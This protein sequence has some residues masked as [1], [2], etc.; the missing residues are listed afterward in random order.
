MNDDGVA[1]PIN[2]PHDMPTPE[3]V[4]EQLAGILA[5]K[6]F[7]EAPRSRQ[8]LTYVVENCLKGDTE[9]LK[10]SVIALEVFGKADFDA[11]I[12]S[13]VRGAAR[14][15]R[16]NIRRFYEEEV[17]TAPV[18]IDL[19]EGHY[20]PTFAARHVQPAI[21]KEAVAPRYWRNLPRLTA[22]AAGLLALA[23]VI[24]LASL[25]LPYSPE[26]PPQYPS[27]LLSAATSTGKKPAFC[28]TRHVIGSLLIT[29]DGKKLYAFEQKGKNVDVFD[30]ATLNI[31][32]TITLPRAVYRA[33]IT[34]AGRYIYAGSMVDGLISIDTRTD[35]VSSVIPTGGPVMHVAVTP[36]NQR[37]F[38]AMGSKGLLEADPNTGHLRVISEHVSPQFV[39]VDPD[40][41]LVYV[42]YMSGGPGGW[43]GHDAVIAYDVKTGNIVH[44]IRQ[45]PRVGG[46]ILFRASGDLAIMNGLDACWTPKY[47]QA[48]CPYVP[49]HVYE[50][51]WPKENNRVEVVALP[52][53]SDQGALTPD[54][55]R[56]VY[57]GTGISVL[58][59]ARRTTVERFNPGRDTTNIA[60]TPKMD[61]VFATVW[62]APGMFV[63]KPDLQECP[64]SKIGLVNL[65]TGD[66]TADD[67]VGT[68]TAV[69]Q[70]PP[71]FAP[72]IAGQAFRFTAKP[73]GF[74]KVAFKDACVMC[75]EEW[76]IGLYVQFA[77]LGDEATILQRTSDSRPGY[78]LSKF[79]DDRIR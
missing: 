50:F 15:L 70:S 34:R 52:Y 22:I 29:P 36:D 5:S 35:Q 37:I 45:V 26:P 73:D 28:D 55:T 11:Q 20:V 46:P 42:S 58:D 78:R 18:L 74:L 63:F 8:L 54:G 12:D 51:L 3:A 62:A 79:R 25:P 2:T 23:L 40:G 57:S 61:R 21:P 71:A 64:K 68:G 47:D 24:A 49:S 16:K 43:P 4:R 48:G 7:A 14:R 38:L 75:S 13:L 32:R 9:A 1:E 41:R 6:G 60:I 19:P 44:A 17:K 65:Y 69:A 59:L 56:Y 10:E 67:A 72:G 39:A 27:R 76:T 31:A 33:A 30:T 77:A 53:G 66:G